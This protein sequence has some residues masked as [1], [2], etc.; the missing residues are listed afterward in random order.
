LELLNYVLLVKALPGVQCG[1][2]IAMR[3]G[4]ET[5]ARVLFFILHEHGS[6]LTGLKYFWSTNCLFLT[7]FSNSECYIHQI[8]YK[9]LVR[10]LWEAMT[11]K[12]IKV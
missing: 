8:Q 7:T 6:V 3:G 4:L 2:E 10:S 11:E 12:V 1:K 5:Y 9:K